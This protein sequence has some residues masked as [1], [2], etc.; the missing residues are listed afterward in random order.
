MDY[1][2]KS[3]LNLLQY[4]FCYMFWFE[5]TRHVASLFLNQGSNPTSPALEGE[6]PA[7]G[8]PRKSM[9]AFL[10]YFY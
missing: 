9:Q 8:L 5:A 6:V 2:F 7:T 10:K 4:G 1:F 3:V